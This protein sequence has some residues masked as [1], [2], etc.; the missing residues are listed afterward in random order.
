M[1]EH[2]SNTEGRGPIARFLATPNDDPIKTVLVALI[3]CLVCSVA[4]SVTAV[5][6]RPLQERNK[7]LAFKREVL[8]VAGLYTP[9]A[10]VETLFR[11]RIDALMVDLATS[12]YLPSLDATSYAPQATARDPQTGIEIKPGD[13]LAG[14]KRRPRYMPVYLVRDGG[15][16]RLVILPVYGS[17]LWSTMYGLLALHPDAN[18]VAGISFYEQAETAGL[19]SEITN[20]LWQAEWVGK[21]IYDNGE[22]RFQLVK[23]GTAEAGPYSVD[24][25]SGASL[26][27]KGV[28]NLVRYWLGNDGYGPYL[29]RLRKQEGDP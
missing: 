28:T 17:G 19:G 3:L 25:V 9:G 21:R 18:T 27:S 22:V 29:A 14:I 16:L 2:P 7:D 11:E 4:V 5:A 15:T 12:E 13:D 1:S 26:T 10:N 24:A 20:P 6:L 23:G 8:Q